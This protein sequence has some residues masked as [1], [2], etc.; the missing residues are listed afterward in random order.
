MSTA[1][2]PTLFLPH[3]AGPCFFMEWEPADTWQPMQRWLT[4]LLP[5]LGVSP[6]ALLVIS[7][8]WEES[9]FTLN[10]QATPAL[11]YD[12]YGFPAHTYQLQWPAPGAPTLA[13][14]VEQLICKAGFATA[15]EPARGLDHGVFIPLKL[16]VPEANISVLQLSLRA[17]M[18]PAAH[19]ALGQALAP[20]R[21]QGVLIIGSGMSFHNIPLMRASLA[22]PAPAATAF[23]D[24]LAEVVTLP[25]AQRTQAL[26]H[27]LQAPGARLAHPDAEHLLP[28]HV[29]AGAA[30]SDRGYRAFHTVAMGVPLAGYVFGGSK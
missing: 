14:Q 29:V 9:A 4:G 28:L 10:S 26:T 16:V 25:E 13:T 27:W 19:L 3:G 30:G 21:E 7:A 1:V 24:W 8:H 17:D 23:D 18:D 12:Y 22:T 15:Q 5:A 2:M 20:L 11:L 6:R